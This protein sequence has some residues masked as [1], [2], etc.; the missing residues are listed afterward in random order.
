MNTKYLQT[1][2]SALFYFLGFI[3]LS[4]RLCLR[5]MLQ[6]WNKPQHTAEPAFDYCSPH[7]I[8]VCTESGPWFPGAC[9]HPLQAVNLAH[10]CYPVRFAGT[11]LLAIGY[12]SKMLHQLAQ[13]LR[14]VRS[15]CAG[16]CSM[17]EESSRGTLLFELISDHLLMEMWFMKAL[18]MEP[19]ETS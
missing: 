4:P 17:A 2:V 14:S 6:C 18:K 13:T 8:F 11:A 1:S 15:L 16:F 12:F 10:G 3:L 19:R 7:S 9:S 5:F